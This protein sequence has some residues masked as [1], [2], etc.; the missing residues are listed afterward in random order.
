MYSEKDFKMK[1]AGATAQLTFELPLPT[2]GGGSGGG[3][4]IDCDPTPFGE[5]ELLDTVTVAAGTQVD[6]YETLEK[7]LLTDLPAGNYYVVWQGASTKP[8]TT[9]GQWRDQI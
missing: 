2:R 3:G 8:T 5:D 1:V 9:T 4:D 6:Y 7:F